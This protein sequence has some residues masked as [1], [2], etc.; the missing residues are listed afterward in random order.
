MKHSAPPARN[1]GDKK[2]R[3]I[4]RFAFLG[5]N[6]IVLDGLF[7]ATQRAP[8][9]QLAFVGI[10]W[11]SKN[12]AMKWVVD[13]VVMAFLAPLKWHCSSEH[14]PQD[15]HVAQELERNAERNGN[16]TRCNK[17]NYLTPW[18]VVGLATCEFL[19]FLPK[20]FGSGEKSPGQLLCVC[21]CVKHLGTGWNGF[22]IETWTLSFR[23]RLEKTTCSTLPFMQF[24]TV[25]FPFR[26][27]CWFLLFNLDINK[28]GVPGMITGLAP[29]KTPVIHLWY[30]EGRSLDVPAN[31]NGW[32]AVSCGVLQFQFSVFR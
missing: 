3:E 32:K 12:C 21:V 1:V 10:F 18:Y 23:D 26:I 6:P 28:Q 25:H 31:L 19:C 9:K 24:S 7:G 20:T 30:Q 5:F 2:K 13:E 15:S 27:Q 14:F 17:V 4:R 22:W 16:V 8:P 29:T 11:P